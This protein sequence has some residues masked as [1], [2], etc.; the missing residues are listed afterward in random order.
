MHLIP[1]YFRPI[2][3]VLLA[4]ALAFSGCLGSPAK[5]PA[6][7]YYVLNS[8]YSAENKAQPVTVLNDTT[9]GV[10][11]IKLSRVLDRPQIVTRTSE[12][13]I[14]VADLERW[15]APLN[16]IVA[17][18]MVDNLSDLLAGAEVLK[19]PWQATLPITYQVTMDITRFDGMP[20]GDVNLRAR[21]GILGENGKKVLASKQSVLNEPTRDNAIAEMVSAQSRL[22]EQLSR[23]IALEIKGFEEQRSGQ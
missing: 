12:N 1:V 10:G 22:L 17:N 5:T 21:W 7:R 18:V 13:E 2:N 9:V 6:T 19:F 20:G 16:E 11:P 15:A 8:T 4:C 3:V 23:E 14:M